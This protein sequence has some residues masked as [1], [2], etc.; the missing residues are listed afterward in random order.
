MISDTLQKAHSPKNVHISVVTPV[1]GFHLNLEGLYTRLKKTLSKITEDFEIIMVNDASPDSAWSIITTL[2]EQD[3]RV[4]G[5]NLSRNFGQHHAIIAGLDSIRGDW[6]VIM[7]CDLQDR[8][9]EIIKLYRKALEGYDMVLGRRV[10]R[11]DKAVNTFFSR[12]FHLILKY[13]SGIDHDHTISNFGIYSKKT[14]D[15]VCQYREQHRPFGIFIHYIG[16]RNTS[17]P[18]EHAKRD[19][20]TSSYTLQ[21]KLAHAVDTL[22]ANSNKPLQ[23]SIRF[24]FLMFIASLGYS[25]WL[26]LRYILYG[27]GVAGWTSLMFSLYIIGGLLFMNMG[28][29]GLYIGK[30]FDETK[31]RPVYFIQETTFDHVDE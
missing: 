29:L 21:K 27:I 9:E 25:V 20:G 16:F 12:L 6:I 17:I 3:S 11:K 13:I 4:R 28:F 26:V 5:I 23:L 31:R 30:I 2:A 8:P 18:V 1:Y 14:I 22:V 7:D 19:T 24:G 15:A 10:K